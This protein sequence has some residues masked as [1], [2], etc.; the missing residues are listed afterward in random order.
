HAS[1]RLRGPHGEVRLVFD[2]LQPG[3]REART[4]VP[5][6]QEPAS[7]RQQPGI[8]GVS[9][10]D[11]YADVLTRRARVVGL[12]FRY[13]PDLPCRRSHVARADAELIE[14]RPHVIGRWEAEWG[15][16]DEPDQRRDPPAD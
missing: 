8:G 11:R 13:S 3:N 9:A 7:L 6:E 2:L 12:V 5:V 10:V 14:Q 4:G 1:A 15:A 16:K